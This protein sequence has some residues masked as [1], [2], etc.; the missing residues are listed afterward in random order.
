P[1]LEEAAH[2]AEELDAAL[3]GLGDTRDDLEERGLPRSVAPDD[4][5]RLAALDLEGHVAE[6]PEVPLGGRAAPGRAAEGSAERVGEGLANV[7]AR[8]PGRPDTIALGQAGDADD[9]RTHRRLHDVREHSLRAAKL[10]HA[11]RDEQQRAHDGDAERA[12]VDG[13][14]ED[15]R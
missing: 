9:G 13:A 3:R 6:R 8:L 11:H 15:G 5:E 2:A 7:P 14:A 10:P 1:D 12:S 4:P